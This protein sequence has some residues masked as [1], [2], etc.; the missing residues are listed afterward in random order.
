MRRY[1]TMCTD[2]QDAHTTHEHRT[3]EL[4]HWGAELGRCVQCR[5][6]VWAAGLEVATVARLE[7]VEAAM[8]W[9]ER[10]AAVKEVEVD[11]EV[12]VSSQ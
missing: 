12:A 2:G 7:A 4:G 6:V 3:G 1:R 5:G 10:A 8:G 11:L 9:E